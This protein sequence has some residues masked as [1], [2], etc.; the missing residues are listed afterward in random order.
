MPVC[1]LRV[2]RSLPVAT[3]HSLIV[4][5]LLPE[6]SVLPSGLNDG[7]ALASV[8]LEDSSPRDRHHPEFQLLQ[9]PL[10]CGRRSRFGQLGH[11]LGVGLCLLRRAPG[12]SKEFLEFLDLFRRAA[13]QLF[14]FLVPGLRCLH[15]RRSNSGLTAGAVVVS[16]IPVQSC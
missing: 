15:L 5:S 3:S 10:D 9:A 7:S 1:P 12:V 4:L 11:S 16:L 13:E 2:A 14:Q 8:P 6:A